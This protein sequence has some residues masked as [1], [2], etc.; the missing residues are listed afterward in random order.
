MRTLIRLERVTKRYDEDIV[1]HPIDLSIYEGE[2]LTLLGPS[3][4]GK[5]TL[6]RT[7]AGFEQ[8]TDGEIYLEDEPM[9][10]QPPYRRNMNM[11]FQQYALFPHMN[12]EDN[13]LFGL[14][15]KKVPTQEQ[16]KRL[17]EVLEYT[18]LKDYRKRFPQQ[19]SGG[20]QQRVA[21]ARAIINRPKVLLLDEPLGAL[22]YQLRKGLQLELKN[23]QKQL[24]ITFIYVTHDQEEA[25]MM[26]DRI[27]ILNAGKIEQIGTPL[28]IYNRP[29]TLFAA[30]F[31]GENN[32]FQQGNRIFSVRPEAI[33]ISSASESTNR[34]SQ[35]Q[36][37]ILDVVFTGATNKVYIAP[38]NETAVILVYDAIKGTPQ[39]RKGQAVKLSWQE[40]DEVDLS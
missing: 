4:C 23:L 35:K 8:L 6:L 34:N 40:L 7:I 16:E 36:G 24:G 26:S 9:K 33:T 14:R 32:I 25:L 2:F 37:E 15:M 13:I 20:Q 30:K 21:I 22:D 28:E 12:V 27:V 19:L 3:G 1:I 5:T 18:Q 39:W 38:S 29:R 10:G 17:A 31:I 11:V